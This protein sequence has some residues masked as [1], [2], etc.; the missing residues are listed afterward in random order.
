MAPCKRHIEARWIA[1]HHLVLIS[2]LGARNVDTRSVEGE[3]TDRTDG[4]GMV[5]AS[6]C[7]CRLGCSNPVINPLL[8]SLIR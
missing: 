7:P 3:I 5:V 2:G 4:V 1:N 6:S 8:C